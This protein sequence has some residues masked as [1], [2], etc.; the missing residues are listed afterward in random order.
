MDDIRDGRQ[1]VGSTQCWFPSVQ[2]KLKNWSSSSG[3]PSRQLEVG[4]CDT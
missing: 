4:E 1:L 2:E 3:G